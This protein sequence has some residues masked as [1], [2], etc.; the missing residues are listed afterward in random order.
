VSVNQ[1]IE[2]KWLLKELPKIEFHKIIQMKQGYISNQNYQI[3]IREEKYNNDVKWIIC[4]KDGKGLV[5]TETEL[6]LSKEMF[7]MFWPLVGEN[8]LSK[9]RMIHFDEAGLKWEID[10]YHSLSKDL[11]TMEL[12]VPYVNF[13]FNIPKE[14]KLLIKEDVTGQ[15]KWSNSSLSRFG[16]K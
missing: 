16:I 2:Y 9:S 13:K 14:I 7:S 5:R 15:G 12:E 6:D 10:N 8:Y 1:E 3:R 4:H 11:V